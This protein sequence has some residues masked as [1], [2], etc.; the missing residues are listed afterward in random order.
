MYSGI[1]DSSFSTEFVG[2]TGIAVR[3]GEPGR[4]VPRRMEA[5]GE[6]D[7]ARPEAQ[8]RLLRRHLNTD[9]FF[10]KFTIQVSPLGLLEDV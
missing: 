1:Y 5:R 10:L 4:G 3:P 2:P 8:Q 9:H 7:E 6:V